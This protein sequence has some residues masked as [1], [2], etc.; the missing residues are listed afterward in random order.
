MRPPQQKPVMPTRFASDFF[1][2]RA[3]VT[4]ESRSPITCVSGTCPTTFITSSIFNCV[5]SPCLK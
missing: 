2:A 5:V 4:V 3:H 1:V